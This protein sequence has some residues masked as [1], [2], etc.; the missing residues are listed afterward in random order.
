[1]GEIGGACHMAAENRYLEAHR[2]N[3]GYY[4]YHSS[5]WNLLLEKLDEEIIHLQTWG[6]WFE[7]F[8][9]FYSSVLSE[10]AHFGQLFTH[11]WRDGQKVKRFLLDCHGLTDERNEEKEHYEVQ[12]FL[13]TSRM[14]LDPAWI[15][16]WKSW[17]LSGWFPKLRDQRFSS[18]EEKNFRLMALRLLL[19]GLFNL[20]K[21]A[22]DTEMSQMDYRVKRLCL[23]A[24]FFDFPGW[25]WRALLNRI[26]GSK[27]IL[28][29]VLKQT[30]NPNL[31]K[32][33]IKLSISLHKEGKG[34]AE[35][36][37][38]IQ[39]QHAIKNEDVLAVDRMRMQI[40]M[41]RALLTGWIAA[42][43]DLAYT[44]QPEWLAI[45][46]TPEEGPFIVE[47][48]CA[49][50]FFEHDLRLLQA[51]AER[52]DIWGK[53]EIANHLL[54][55][56]N[57]R[58]Q[59]LSYRLLIYNHLYQITKKL[60]EL[61][62]PDI[63]L[64]VFDRWLPWREN[65]TIRTTHINLLWLARVVGQALVHSGNPGLVRDL[66]RLW[67][68][69][70]LMDRRLEKVLIVVREE[71]KNQE[72]LLDE[73]N[74]GLIR[75]WLWQILSKEGS[76]YLRQPVTML[77]NAVI[78]VLIDRYSKKGNLLTVMSWLCKRWD[79]L[80]T[81][82]FLSSKQ[83]ENR[84][85]QIMAAILVGVFVFV[86]MTDSD[87]R[88][89]PYHSNLFLKVYQ[90]AMDERYWTNHDRSFPPDK[91]FYVREIERAIMLHKCLRLPKR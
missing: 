36:Q 56:L 57:D 19:G 3:W 88:D 84:R 37:F 28:Q 89:K 85:K 87:S 64:W 29:R 21:Q 7:G 26:E 81:G 44:I 6:S 47:S 71:L 58:H 11:S 68:P 70:N 62:R 16:A 73:W 48:I 39:L 76:E 75:L 86:N 77:E 78:P 69:I 10:Q 13:E 8:V 1:M 60:F 46:V 22:D 42:W 91:P 41:R 18:E 50:P 55:L 30:I 24:V 65:H 90:I 31:D 12:R 83:E 66:F 14:D 82:W 5:Q 49:H 4:Q 53:I 40:P 80:E 35:E 20:T 17:L 54:D 51:I 79:K 23:F 27:N 45:L 43:L 38:F 2:K 52:A 32:P 74:Q 34:T 72:D 61:N 33:L 63:V 59:R 15:E 67:K 25:H 9:L